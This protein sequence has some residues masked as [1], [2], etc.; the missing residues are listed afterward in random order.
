VHIGLSS[1][2]TEPAAVTADIHISL[3]FADAKETSPF[4][5][6][7]LDNGRCANGVE[8]TLAVTQG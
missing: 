5:E 6:E 4:G 8:E 7:V 1:R 2:W 3:P